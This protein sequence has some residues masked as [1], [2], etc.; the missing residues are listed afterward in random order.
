LRGRRTQRAYSR[1]LGCRS[2]APYTW[3]SGRRFPSAERFFDIATRSG[4]DVPRALTGFFRTRPAW[5]REGQA[6]DRDLVVDLLSELRGQ[7]TLVELARATGLSRFRL[8]RWFAGE[9]EPRLPDFLALVQATSYRLLDFVA[10]FVDPEGM[11]ELQAPWRALQASRRA[12][13]SVP[14]CHVVLRLLETRAFVGKESCAAI[15][16]ATALGITPSE[17]ETS[18]ELLEQSG[19]I[20]RADR[21]YR[22]RQ[23]DNVDLADDP[24]RVKE[25]KAWAA[26]LGLERLEQGRQGLFSYN[27]FCVSERDYGK[28]QQLHRAYFRQLR[29]LVA[30]SHPSERVLMVNMQLFPLDAR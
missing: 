2:N 15:D 23:L 26:R 18:L 4:V 16:V 17:A 3:E 7:R 12:A 14:W 25:L 21:S 5:L 27:L 6:V 30:E 8:A 10:A 29:A 20:E 22:V 11:A 28:I 13:Y 9:T 24:E 1:L 19:Q